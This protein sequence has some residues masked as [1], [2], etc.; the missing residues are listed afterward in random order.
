VFKVRKW[1]FIFLNKRDIFVFFIM[2]IPTGRLV[3]V[4]LTHILNPEFSGLGLII[5]FLLRRSSCGRRVTPKYRDAS[6]GGFAF[7]TP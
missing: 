6:K 4:V 1:K 3:R 2:L 5:P 7:T